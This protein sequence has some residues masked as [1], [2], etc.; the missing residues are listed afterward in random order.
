MNN[1][2]CEQTCRNVKGSSQ[3][4]CHSGYRLN[5]DMK[6]CQGIVWTKRFEQKY[7]VHILSCFIINNLL[8]RP[9][10]AYISSYLSTIVPGS[11]SLCIGNLKTYSSSSL[12]I[13]ECTDFPTICS[14][15]CTN[16]PGGYKCTCPPG[17][18]S[19]DNG[20]LCL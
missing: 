19:I 13:D 10:V 4:G 1:G 5:L 9:F 17:K 18:R 16:I 20:G 3:C 8:P 15:N 2:G 6:T 11:Y 12:D 14:H 7:T